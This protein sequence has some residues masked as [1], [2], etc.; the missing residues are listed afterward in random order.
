MKLCCNMLYSRLSEGARI[1]SAYVYP[2]IFAL[3]NGISRN[4]EMD[5]HSHPE[6][7]TV[8]KVAY[9]CVQGIRDHGKRNR[10]LVQM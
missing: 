7:E 8:G 1:K 5:P 10:N 9:M 4:P 2:S 3:P 6:E